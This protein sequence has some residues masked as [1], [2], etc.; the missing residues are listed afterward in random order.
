[1][2]RPDLEDDRIMGFYSKLKTAFSLMRTPGKLIQ[3]LAEMGFFN[4]MPDEKYLKLVFQGQTDRRLDLEDPKTFNEKLQWIKL[5][6]RNPL[7]QR[8]VDKYEVKAYVAEAIGAQYVIPTLGLWDNAREI[9]FDRLPDRFVLK[10]THDSGSVVLC[11]D[12]STFDAAEAVKL[13]NRQLKKNI[14]WFAREWPYKNVKP[15]VIAEPFLEDGTGDLRD[16]K[17]FCFNGEVKFFKVDFDRFTNHRANYYGIDRQFIPIRE[18]QVPNDPEARLILPESIDTM[19]ELARKLSKDIPFVRVDF[20]DIHGTVYFGEMTFFPG[21]GFNPFMPPEW[22]ER[23]G[24]YLELP[25]AKK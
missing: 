14:Y 10:C 23:I 2:V 6:D 18:M 25:G 12:R 21:A 1:M 24:G 7:Y 3:P 11:R 5:Y 15:R 16:Y 22:E 17:L 20:Y 19:I 8:L 9:A 13:L 4:W